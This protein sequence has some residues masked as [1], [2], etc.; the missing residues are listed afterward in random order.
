MEVAVSG[1]PEQLRI[2]QARAALGRLS[3]T[4]WQVSKLLSAVVLAIALTA[5]VWVHTQD[6]WFVYA[7]DVQFNNLVHLHA[8]DLYAAA[9]VEGWNIFWLQPQEVRR[10]LL[11]HP[12]IED[13]RVGLEL[14]AGITVH[15]EEMAPVAL[16]ITNAGTLWLAA[17][18]GTM[19]V[20]GEPDPNLPQII[21]SLQEART[22]TE[23][24][25][26]TMNPQ[27]LASAIA[28]AQAVPELEGKVR[29]NRSVGLNFPLPKPPIWVYWGDGYYM[30]QKLDNLAAAR[31]AVKQSDTP[32]QI[33][34]VR[35]V[36]RP[37]FR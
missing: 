18:G 29:Y 19:P 36:E 10:R 27:I 24:Q 4:G 2:D 21:D 26:L 7:E 17:D 14:P 22:V 20:E 34:D 5:I 33:I 32:A 15:V 12:W 13:A 31:E 30:Q 16:W 35:F 6:D 8:E 3:G 37:Y 11:E 23:T 1:L 28:L 9:Q 25:R